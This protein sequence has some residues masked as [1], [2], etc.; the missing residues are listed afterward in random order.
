LVWVTLPWLVG[1][2]WRSRAPRPRPADVADGLQ[3]PAIVEP[4]DPFQ[5]RELDGLER[6][7]LPTSMDDLG[8]STLA[9]AALPLLLCPTLLLQFDFVLKLAFDRIDHPHD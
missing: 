2:A 5:R 1:P 6:P 4:V 9:E 7:P 8:L 3:K